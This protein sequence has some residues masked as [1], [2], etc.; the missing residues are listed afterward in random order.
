MKVSVIWLLDLIRD[1]QTCFDTRWGLFDRK[2]SVGMCWRVSTSNPANSKCWAWRSVMA[3]LKRNSPKHFC[4]SAHTM[5]LLW[6]RRYQADYIFISRAWSHPLIGLF[7]IARFI[8]S[9]TT[10]VASL[11]TVASI[12][13]CLV[14]ISFVHHNRLWGGWGLSRAMV[15][16]LR[17]RNL[18][19]EPNLFEVGYSKTDSKPGPLYRNLIW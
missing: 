13:R 5:T 2:V 17:W 15:K 9:Q 19:S 16:L 8:M 7:S 10:N 18:V 3:C 14:V 11:V 1:H 4:G 12:S 6:R